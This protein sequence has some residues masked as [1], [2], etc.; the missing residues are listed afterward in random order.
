MRKVRA[1]IAGVLVVAVG[2]TVMA[3]PAATTAADPERQLDVRILTVD[4][5]QRIKVKRKLQ[6]LVGC[7]KNCAV[8]VEM[9]LIMPGDV[10]KAKL[11]G[12]I[13]AFSAKA[14][15]VSLNNAALRYL[16]LTYPRSRFSVK[17]TATDISNGDVVTKRKT[18]RFRR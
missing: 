6:V 11:K 8:V 14:P 18:F 7:T 17:V 3:S 16:K 12:G 15:Y 2:A 4:G 1:V 5:K 10:L 9:K 13:K